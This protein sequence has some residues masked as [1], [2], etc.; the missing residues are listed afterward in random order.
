[1]YDKKE[2]A[3]LIGE[4][5]REWY[6]TVNECAQSC[7]GKSSVFIFGRED[8]GAYAARCKGDPLVCKCICETV[9]NENGECLLVVQNS[10]DM[11]R[12]V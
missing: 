11:F 12:Y 9:A 4:V 2:C 3:G 7:Y 6:E 8:Y 1:M 10:Y 5:G